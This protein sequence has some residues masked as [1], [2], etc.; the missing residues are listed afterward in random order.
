[1]GSSLPPYVPYKGVQRWK[2]GR[3]RD[4]KNLV[5]CYHATRS[6]NPRAKIG[7]VSQ[8]SPREGGG[9]NVITRAKGIQEVEKK[10]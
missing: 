3:N 1:M 4:R 8:G 7:S 6:L 2:R 5:P 9:I 10:N